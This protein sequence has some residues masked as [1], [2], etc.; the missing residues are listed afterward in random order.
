MK[1]GFG[2]KIAFGFSVLS[3]ASSIAAMALFAFVYPQRGGADPVVASLLAIIFFL[4][5]CGVALY[6]ISQPPRFEL[7]PWDQG[8]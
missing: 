2:K 4:A 7:Q 8:Q 6:F 5:S 3:F 1:R